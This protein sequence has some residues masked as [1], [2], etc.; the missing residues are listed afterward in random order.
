[1]AESQKGYLQNNEIIPINTRINIENETFIFLRYINQGTFSNSYEIEDLFSNRKFAIKIHRI[2]HIYTDQGIN[3]VKIL[4][5]LKNNPYIVKMFAYFSFRN[6]FCIVQELLSNNLYDAI[7]S[8][9]FRGFG[10]YYVKVIG[11][12]LLEALQYL[13]SKGIV[14]SDLKPENICLENNPGRKLRVKLIDFGSSFLESGTGTCCVQSR[15]YR[16]PESIFGMKITTEADLWSFGC[17]LYE[18]IMGMPLFPGG[19]NYEQ[20]LRYVKLIGM[21]SMN[22]L[23]TGLKI[24]DFFHRS[25]SKWFLDLNI[26]GQKADYYLLYCNDT[27]FKSY[28]T[29]KK[30]EREIHHR[31]PSILDN[32]YLIDVLFR[33]LKMEPLD[34]IPINKLLQ[35][36]YFANDESKIPMNNTQRLRPIR[37]KIVRP[38]SHMRPRHFNFDTI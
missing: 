28:L 29:P 31:T 21:P 7:K 2:G 35:H 27:D 3:E 8:M 5:N 19:D 22:I 17:I 33:I 34:R 37:R 15:F 11:R 13:K 36:S 24:D 38:S 23:R 9:D 14:H 6:Q 30:L 25:S 12:Q 1:M 10:H 20:V 4:E 32:C 16:S 18:L 26:A